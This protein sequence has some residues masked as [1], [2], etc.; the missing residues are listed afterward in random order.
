VCFEYFLSNWP[1]GSKHPPLILSASS[2]LHPYTNQLEYFFQRRG[3]V[4]KNIFWSAWLPTV[5]LL[6]IIAVLFASIVLWWIFVLDPQSFKY[7]ADCF[8]DHNDLIHWCIVH[9]ISHFIHSK[10]ASL[11]QG[12]SPSGGTDLPTGGG[13]Q[14]PQLQ[15]EVG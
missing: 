12:Y 11:A 10:S 13:E 3:R 15:I 5:M 1:S 8:Q 6:M 7:S 2:L 14:I 4:C 9:K